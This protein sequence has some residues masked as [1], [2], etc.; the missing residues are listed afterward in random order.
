MWLHLECWVVLSSEFWASRFH[1]W[2]PPAPQT[3]FRTPAVPRALPSCFS[4]PAPPGRAPLRAPFPH[5]PLPP[6][7]LQLSAG[8][9]WGWPLG[10]A[11]V[12]SLVS[13]EAPR[14]PGVRDRP[15]QPRLRSH[16]PCCS[17]GAKEGTPS[18]DWRL[19]LCPAPCSVQSGPGGDLGEAGAGAQGPSE[20]GPG[21]LRSPPHLEAGHSALEEANSQAGVLGH[22]LVKCLGRKMP[23]NAEVCNP[24]PCH[25]PRPGA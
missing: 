18:V 15:L 3:L 2:G 23:W 5:H 8:H 16:R 20:E 9:L 11:A 12:H 4:A 24:P 22:G 25:R 13:S 19:W 10:R 14:P 7:R 6:G 21:A 1:A 17:E